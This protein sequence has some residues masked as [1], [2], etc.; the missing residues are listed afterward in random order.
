MD[1]GETH[2]RGP[3]GADAPAG[4]S[5]R[6]ARVTGPPSTSSTGISIDIIMWAI[7]WTLN[8]AAEYAPRP[9]D[10]VTSS[11]TAPRVN[12]IVRPTGH[13][14]PRRRSRTTPRR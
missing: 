8:I 11:N 12:E 5:A 14:S 9:D 1:R 10:V 4:D 13:S 7:M 3:G 6:R 2:S